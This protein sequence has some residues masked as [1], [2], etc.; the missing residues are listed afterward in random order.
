[1]FKLY[2]AADDGSLDAGDL[3]LIATIEA[4]MDESTLDTLNLTRQVNVNYDE[5]RIGTSMTDVLPVIPEPG[6]AILGSFGLLGLL[7][8]RR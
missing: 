2:N 4:D 6:I 8:R 1:M 5:V 3:T 7:R